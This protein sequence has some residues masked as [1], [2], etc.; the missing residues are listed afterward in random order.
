MLLMRALVSWDVKEE[1]YCFKISWFC[2]PMGSYFYPL[3]PKI[4][5]VLAA[6]RFYV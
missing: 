3:F 2:S 6:G 4:L 5:Y 1:I